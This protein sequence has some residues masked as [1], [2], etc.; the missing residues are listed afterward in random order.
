[1]SLD[2]L[3]FR[4]KQQLIDEVQKLIKQKDYETDEM[5]IK[6]ERYEELVDEG[7][8]IIEEVFHVVKI[9]EISL[10]EMRKTI[11]GKEHCVFNCDSEFH[12]HKMHKHCTE[13]C[14]TKKY[15]GMDI[16]NEKKE[17]VEEILLGFPINK[18]D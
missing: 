2:E 10:D 8:D 4:T 12:C 9:L 3:K 15:C 5:L 7:H 14:K 16:T 13:E 17:V 11:C 18:T 6:I 1:M